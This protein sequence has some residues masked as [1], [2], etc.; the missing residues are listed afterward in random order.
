MALDIA[1]VLRNVRDKVVDI[2]QG[3]LTDEPPLP[4]RYQDIKDGMLYIHA[5]YQELCLVIKAGKDLPEK[6][7]IPA[8]KLGAAGVKFA[9]DLA[10]TKLK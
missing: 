5:A 3:R 2:D 7:I 1:A 10:T 9:C 4:I 8:I 6:C